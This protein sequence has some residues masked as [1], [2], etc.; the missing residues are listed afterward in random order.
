MAPAPLQCRPAPRS[1]PRRRSGTRARRRFSEAP[2]AAAAAQVLALDMGTSG[3]KATLVAK[4]GSIERRASVPYASPTRVGSNGEVEQRP[5]EWLEAFAKASRECL[6][7]YN[8]H[9]AAVV[10][11]GTMQNTVVQNREACLMYSDVRARFEAKWCEAE[12]G[13]SVRHLN[14]Y[15]GAAS[16][17]A[18]WRWLANNEPNLLDTGTLLFGAHSHVTYHLC[19]GMGVCDRT[20]AATT[21]LLDARTGEWATWA[22]DA[23]DLD[24]AR[25]PTLMD[26]DAD[27]AEVTRA[28]ADR[29][30][31]PD[32]LVGARVIHGCGDLGATTLGAGARTYLYLGTSGWVART[33]GSTTLAS[34][35]SEGIFDVLHPHTD[36]T[37]KAASMTTTGGAITWFADAI[38]N[39]DLKE[40]DRIAAEVPPGVGG[41]LFMPHLNGERSPFLDPNARGAYLNLSSATGKPELARATLEGVAL[42]Y[43]SLMRCLRCDAPSSR[44]GEAGDVLPLVGGGAKSDLW[45]QILADVLNVRIAAEPDSDAVA[46]RGVAQ[47]AFQA[48]G[49]ADAFSLD[50][51]DAADSC[52]IFVPNPKATRVYDAAFRVFERVYPMLQTAGVYDLAAPEEGLPKL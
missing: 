33:V 26:A 23:C 4:D 12:L 22:L 38:L 18:K 19:D 1:T 2:R 52:R 27:L 13:E 44:L 41:T 51:A 9:V 32:A 15:K 10:L 45:P 24:N 11:A 14:N 29:L 49:E 48:L 36:K 47:L 46:A 50:C 25:L 35:S 5:A 30:G 21:G 17:L 40:L 42:G 28:A 20:T 8:G 34:S 7:G 6:K 43:R 3:C 37:I 16:V 39:A 31:L